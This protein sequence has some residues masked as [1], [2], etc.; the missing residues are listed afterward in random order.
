LDP[1]FARVRFINQR[2]KGVENVVADH[3]SKIPNAPVETI[4]INENFPDGHIL[5][6]CKDHWYVDIANYLATGQTPSS[7]SKQ[8]KYHFFTQIRFFSGMNRIYSNISLIRLL[9]SVFLRINII[10]C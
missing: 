6:M 9:E 5:V 1:S 3:L 7:W 2:Q 8:D 10:I 4:P